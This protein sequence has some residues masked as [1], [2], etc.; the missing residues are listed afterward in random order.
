MELNKRNRDILSEVISA[1]IITGEPVG[2]KQLAN[3]TPLNCSSATIRAKM[4]ELCELG[5]LSQ[6]HTSAAR[7]P[8][9]AGYR[10]FIGEL[11]KNSQ[12]TDEDKRI[13][14]SLLPH[15]VTS[16]ERLMESA[17]NALADYTGCAAMMTTP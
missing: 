6:P 5:L 12:A 2:S 9:A 17:C 4:N 10:Y 16:P 3:S 11:I 7:V 14:D 15:A 1:Y 8:T 13:I